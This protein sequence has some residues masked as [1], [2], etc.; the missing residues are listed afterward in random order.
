MN[1]SGNTKVTKVY[2]TVGNGDRLELDSNAN[3]ITSGSYTIKGS[4]ITDSVSITLE[5]T[6]MYTVTF[7]AGENGKLKA[8][9]DSDDSTATKSIEKTFDKDHQLAES[10]IP[11]PVGDA[12]Y[13][14]DAWNTTL[15]G[16]SV[17]ADVTYTASFKDATYTVTLPKGM[18]GL[19]STA[20]HG[21][22]IT[23]TPVI[24][25]KIV[26]SVSYTIGDN[27]TAIT[28][29]GDGS[30]TINGSDITGDIT[31]STETIDG[32]VDFIPYSSYMAME[33]GKKIVVVTAAELE[34]GKYT[35]NGGSDLFWSSKYNGYVAF[36]GSSETAATVAS[37]LV[38][39]DDGSAVK[40]AYDGDIDGVD[41]ADSVD[42]G[43]VNDILHDANLY[44]DVDDK[45]RFELDVMGDMSVT[46]G[47]IKWI[48]EEAV[49]KHSTNSTTA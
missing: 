28:A 18:T 21:G 35:L 36:A 25:D 30:Y 1:V 17:T 48:L 10:D 34:N 32:S 33:S 43:M 24:T 40:I 41:G 7:T 2:Y 6:D 3:G 20:T 12:G 22:N 4:D 8:S 14:F 19:G 45:M 31:I 9:K 38:K 37:K 15:V 49:G 29:N 26:T 39:S 5:S 47:D 11:T 44:Y 13:T 42:A 27:T 23:F 46:T 16:T